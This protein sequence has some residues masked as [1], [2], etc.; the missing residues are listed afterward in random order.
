MEK[1]SSEGPVPTL[2]ES[3][4]EPYAKIW[5]VYV[6]E[7]EKYDKAL[8]DSWRGNMNG[9]L[10]FAG[11]FSV[12]LTVFIA[13]S[14]KSLQ[15]DPDPS[16]TI[17]IHISTQLANSTGI[18]PMSQAPS[19]QNLTAALICNTLWFISLGL[20]LASAMMATLVD[21]WAHDFLQRTEMVSSPVKRARIFSY[22]YYGMQRFRMHEVVTLVPF[23]LHMALL[24]F[25]GGL[26]AFL[27]PVNKSVAFV[28][29]A[30]LIII[31]LLYV[32]MTVLPV[33]WFDCPY[34]TPLSNVLWSIL[35]H[36]S[37]F[38]H[39]HFPSSEVKHQ[40]AVDTHPHL[41]PKM[42]DAMIQKATVR[43][44]AG[45][46]EARDKR[47][48]AWTVKSLADD[49][50]LEPFIEGIPNAIWGPQGRRIK[51]DSLVR[52]L[53][54]DP[55]VLLGSRIQHHLMLS[56]EKGLLDFKVRN[57]RQIS[58]LKALWCLGMMAGKNNEPVQPLSF[59][60]GPRFL[61]LPTPEAAHYLPSVAALADWN[62]LCSLHGHV[63]KLAASLRAG[64][65]ALNEGRL[66][67]MEQYRRDLEE[68]LTKRRDCNWHYLIPITLAGV[69]LE[70]LS[71]RDLSKDGPT[72]LHYS[73]D[74]IQQ[75]SQVI[76]TIPACWN[77]VQ[78]RVLLAFLQQSADLN[79]PPYEF[80]STCN[81]I[82][83][84][85]E[86]VDNRI[87]GNVA[88][89]FADT[90]AK[91]VRTLAHSPYVSH[92]D[93]ILGMLL[94]WFDT[95]HQ[96]EVDLVNHVTDSVVEYMNNRNSNEAI[97]RILQDCNLTR[98]WDW[99]TA[100]LLTCREDFLG[101]V[102]KAMW[103]L[104]ALFPGVSSPDSRLP[105]WPHF[106][107]DTLS[108]VPVAPYKAS[109]I[110]LIK[111]HIL[112]A[113]EEAEILSHL[114]ALDAQ[115][116]ANDER[117]ISA[118]LN[119]ELRKI[120][121]DWELMMA[122]CSL[123]VSLATTGPPLQLLQPFPV[124][125]IQTNQAY[126]DWRTQALVAVRHAIELIPHLHQR[127]EEVRLTITT[128]FIQACCSARDSGGLPY[129]ALDT[130]S[131]S[132]MPIL[133]VSRP[134]HPDNQINFATALRSL[135]ETPDM[136]PDHLC[137]L[138]SLTTSS[139]FND[140]L[141][142]LDDRQAIATLKSGFQLASM[143][144]CGWSVVQA[145]KLNDICTWLDAKEHGLVP[146]F[147]LPPDQNHAGPS[148]IGP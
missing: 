98:I 56:C 107:G 108:V 71:K 12:I 113:Y 22:L 58:C 59:L 104:T 129:R 18:V 117:S 63:K 74:W 79:S 91:A 62:T 64:E 17:L 130:F 40:T 10:I 78:Y 147:L 43:D 6:S 24:F 85:L 134:P 145:K 42:A 119:A 19:N 35:G 140:G 96:L 13:E 8:V 89:T 77:S 69:D 26:F 101:D 144:K 97:C 75:V 81:T 68:F 93:V 51:Y 87:A 114:Q 9:I 15:T 21:Q 143:F 124:Y 36:T 34:K 16:V 60:Q 28:A 66:P 48:L 83:A 38:I 142:W 103:H 20:S 32:F 70:E 123:M 141:P 72:T 118:T 27:F 125:T 131:D 4:D 73:T 106:N 90:V 25:F 7:A 1:N 30:I 88:A 100:R 115:I 61:P 57:R 2:Y 29:L 133:W 55:Q 112:N 5:S 110:A 53:L 65:I 122:V 80:E 47:A 120:E 54:D 46:R 95:N 128:E 52:G 67:N 99:V 37:L 138:Q 44:D 39:R 111:S 109:V 86:P 102:S 50:E 121:N 116:K 139:L 126:R 3:G 76:N 49:V 146:E 136:T 31:G 84:G 127:M 132:L 92:V 41:H 135:A 137:L 45:H 94:P 148:P 23:L 82:Q 33:V 11:L 14:Y 105:T